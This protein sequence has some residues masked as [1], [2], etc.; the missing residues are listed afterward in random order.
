M[1]LHKHRENDPWPFEECVMVRFIWRYIIK[2]VW[3]TGSIDMSWRLGRTKSDFRE[4]DKVIIS[5][6]D[7]DANRSFSQCCACLRAS[8]NPVTWSMWGV[9]WPHHHLILPF[10]NSHSFQ[11]LKKHG[12]DSPRP[13]FFYGNYRERIEMV[14]CSYIHW[15]MG[16]RFIV[17]RAPTISWSSFTVIMEL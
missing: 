15:L 12:I 4:S 10:S 13:S 7:V 6:S 11:V 17:C 5:A 2:E 3:V 1:V 16:L 9:Y 8:D 14:Y